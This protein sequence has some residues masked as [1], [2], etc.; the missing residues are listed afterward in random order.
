[1]GELRKPEKPSLCKY[2]N[3]PERLLWYITNH[4]V[5]KNV[6]GQESKVIHRCAYYAVSKW[7]DKNIKLMRS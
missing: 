4:S 6:L 7:I 1:M 2:I 5:N 3:L